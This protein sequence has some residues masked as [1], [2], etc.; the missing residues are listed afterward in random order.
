LR[1]KNIHSND[2]YTSSLK[3]RE[4]RERNKERGEIRRHIERKT[5]RQ[6]AKE[7]REKIE[8]SVFRPS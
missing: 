7:R 1:I 2:R 6:T 4:R 3:K 8:S 5:D